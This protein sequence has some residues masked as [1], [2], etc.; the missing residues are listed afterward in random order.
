MH[1]ENVKNT[2]KIGNF[3]LIRVW[4]TSQNLSFSLTGFNQ[5]ESA[6]LQK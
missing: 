2:G 3:A 6:D 4:Q 5:S 1:R